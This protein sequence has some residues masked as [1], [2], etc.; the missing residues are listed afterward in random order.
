MEKR[1]SIPFAGVVMTGFALVLALL[2]FTARQ[3][4]PAMAQTGTGTGT[5]GATNAMSTTA[6]MN[7]TDMYQLGQVMMHALM[8]Q[9]SLD[10]MSI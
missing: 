4:N 7:E 5:T 9:D 3:P 8:A 6:M 2:A 10:K 1:R